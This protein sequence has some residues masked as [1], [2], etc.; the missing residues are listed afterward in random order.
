MHLGK[1]KNTALNHNHK[2]T[3]HLRDLLK[4]EHVAVE[5]II[6]EVRALRDRRT[7]LRRE[8]LG[9]RAWI[10]TV[11]LVFD[12]NVGRDVIKMEPLWTQSSR[13][14]YTWGGAES[15]RPLCNG[16]QSRRHTTK[17]IITISIW[18]QSSLTHSLDAFLE[19]ERVQ[20][21]H[22]SWFIL[23]RL[24]RTPVLHLHVGLVLIFSRFWKKRH[25]NKQL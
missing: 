22:R 20:L 18:S 24:I 10:T 19:R 4:L 12:S 6:L 9:Q 25:I 23:E 3:T 1:E 14:N 17:S 8:Q 7:Q 5:N 13:V 11:W 2:T 21:P 16:M 15:R